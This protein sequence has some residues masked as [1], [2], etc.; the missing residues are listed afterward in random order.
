MPLPDALFDGLSAQVIHALV[1]EGIC[2]VSFISEPPVLRTAKDVLA[3]ACTTV[4]KASQLC[5]Q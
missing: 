2:C 4:L 3:L 5:V 1:Y